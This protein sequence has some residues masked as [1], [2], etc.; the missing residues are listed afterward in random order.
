M[1]GHTRAFTFLELVA[2]MVIIGIL[3]SVVIPRITTYTKQARE[4]ACRA[5][6]GTIN[7]QVELYYVRIGEWPRGD[8]VDI[9]RNPDHFPNLIPDCPVTGYNYWIYEDTHRVGGHIEG[10][11]ESHKELGISKFGDTLVDSQ[12]RLIAGLSREFNVEFRDLSGQSEITRYANIVYGDDGN[13]IS[14]ELDLYDAFG[15]L[16][17]TC[18]ASNV[19]WDPDDTLKS[20]TFSYKDLYGNLTHSIDKEY[21]G[22]KLVDASGAFYYEDQS[23]KSYFA[24][25][26]DGIERNEYGKIKKVTIEFTD[27]TTARNPVEYWDVERYFD[28]NG[29]ELALRMT[30]KDGSGKAKETHLSYGLVNHP[31]NK[32]KVENHLLF[33]GAI[34]V[35]PNAPFNLENVAEANMHKIRG[36]NGVK[37]ITYDVNSGRETGY[38]E[39]KIRIAWIDGE[40]SISGVDYKY[41]NYTYDSEGRRVGYTR[42]EMRVDDE[43]NEIVV[44][45]IEVMEGPGDVRGGGYQ[46][47]SIIERGPDGIKT[48][49]KEYS[50][51]SYGTGTGLL[52]GF[53][54]IDRDAAGNQKERQVYTADAFDDIGRH[55]AYTQ[56]NYD[57]HNL[58]ADKISYTDVTFYKTGE[59]QH[60]LVNVRTSSYKFETTDSS[61]NFVESYRYSDIRY[62][63]H[64]EKATY[65]WVQYGE[66][67][68]EIAS[69]DYPPPETP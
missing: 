30:F 8:L 41:S 60:E 29:N 43:G 40:P 21:E 11:P 61:G 42:N 49:S 54:M 38:T 22:G 5:N 26:E 13:I 44:R 33:N 68:S 7:E 47:A 67:G 52:T 1:K 53:E 16:I 35:N 51:Y 58:K 3:V 39:T 27:T 6:I 4:K 65:H 23:V 34:E 31:D 63:A 59:P 50:K 28:A 56:Q 24:V 46:A 12:A 18:F 37:D 15:N 62:D 55:T 25:T 64:G 20:A 36:V 14:A 45:S 48:G 2:S 19:V 57:E 9:A 32:R 69:G 17:C 66:D 10:D